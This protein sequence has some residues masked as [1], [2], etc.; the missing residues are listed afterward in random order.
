MVNIY[1][2]ECTTGVCAVMYIL[3]CSG[4]V[5]VMYILSCICDSDVCVV[6]N[7]FSCICASGVCDVMYIA[8]CSCYGSTLVLCATRHKFSKDE[9]ISHKYSRICT[10]LVHECICTLL[11][12]EFIRMRT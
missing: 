6:T 10:L 4:V 1:N 5:V 3:P 9:H 11:V 8:S 2:C 7:T 12:H